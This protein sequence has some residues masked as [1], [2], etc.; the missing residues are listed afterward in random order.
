MAGQRS[1]RMIGML[2]TAA[3]GLL[4]ASQWAATASPTGA[5]SASATVPVRATLDE[6]LGVSHFMMTPEQEA[7][8]SGPELRQNQNLIDHTVD[9]LGITDTAPAVDDGFAGLVVNPA[10]AQMNL[11]WR[12]E[13]PATV[14]TALDAVSA[15]LRVTVRQAAY[16]RKELVDRILASQPLWDGVTLAIPREDGSGIVL[17]IETTDVNVEAVA[18]ALGVPTEA[19]VEGEWVDQDG[20]RQS[21][22]DPWWGGMLMAWGGSGA[23]SEPDRFCST[24]FAVLQGVEGRILSAAHCDLSGNLKWNNGNLGNPTRFT[25]GDGYVS[26]IKSIDSMLINPVN[27]TKGRVHT[28]G[29]SPGVSDRVLK[30]A[31]NNVGDYVA[32]SGANS[33]EH[34]AL[35]IFNDSLDRECNGYDCT[36]VM[37]GTKSRS[38]ISSVGGDSGGPWLHHYDV[39][40]VVAKGVQSGSLSRWWAYCDYG[41]YRFDPG[42]QYVDRDGDG[43]YRWEPNCS[44][45]SL[46]L[47]IR[48]VMKAWGVT[49]E[50]IE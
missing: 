10:T 17:A 9:L 4:M 47:P 13:L 6:A 19:S 50:T 29:I 14:R 7:A 32:S 20:G 40:R 30:S 24:A 16:S 12:G 21:A 36:K 31:V 38:N 44:Y 3:A 35:T 22:S 15:P 42:F 48:P 41:D 8:V 1:T 18:V 33:G 39:D 49:L 11:W 45:R 46:Y 2:L 23:G 34:R 28:G 27:G 26:V 5:A 43:Q 25:Q 37:A